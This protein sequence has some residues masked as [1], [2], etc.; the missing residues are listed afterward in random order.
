MVLSGAYY[1][2]PSSSFL[3]CHSVHITPRKM[4]QES[5][6]RWDLK[7]MEEGIARASQ[8]LL[9]QKL[10][11]NTLIPVSRLPIELLTEVFILY[12]KSQVAE[13]AQRL[14][15]DP[16]RRLSVYSWIS[17]SQ[18]C[19]Q[20]RQVALQTP[21][22][23]CSIVWTK[24][25][26][27]SWISE[28]L[29][30]SKSLLLRIR[31]RVVE[32]ADQRPVFPHLQNALA[33][34]LPEIHRAHSIDISLP[35]RFWSRLRKLE[36]TQLP[37]L[38]TL[39][40]SSPDVNPRMP[41]MFDDCD[42]PKLDRLG[43]SRIRMNCKHPILRGSMVALTLET[44][45][46]QDLINILAQMPRLAHLD[47][48]GSFV[49]LRMETPHNRVSFPSLATL[50]L[51]GNPIRLA[52]FWRS[53]TFPTTTCVTLDFK[54]DVS[55]L[56]LGAYD[57][58]FKLDEIFRS[59]PRRILCLSL[60]YDLRASQTHVDLHTEDPSLDLTGADDP[61][62]QFRITIQC[63]FPT[64]R[65]IIR[66]FVLQL[67]LRHVVSLFIQ[68]PDTSLSL[69][70]EYVLLLP[71]MP[72]LNLVRTTGFR[73]EH[74]NDIV[75]TRV[76]WHSGSIEYL[77]PQLRTLVIRNTSNP[78]DIDFGRWLRTRAT[79]GSMFRR[80]ILEKCRDI[81][82]KG[83]EAL[84]HNLAEVEVEWDNRDLSNEPSEKDIDLGSSSPQA[85]D[86]TDQADI[87]PVY[88]IEERQFVQTF[89][90]Y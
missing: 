12:V 58:S 81:N 89:D 27:T 47:L 6:P 14:R 2:I 4:P 45:V 40:L 8:A 11:F 29:A 51:V 33:V 22:L 13:N 21:I 35:A 54:R 24:R 86:N 31:I 79:S 88:N 84:K 38:K 48:S 32:G 39:T 61:T 65:D 75:R 20:W 49:I 36:A 80:L 50:R 77:V 42:M 68:I 71:K 30:R 90:L 56:R 76:A 55:N 34:L 46:T 70:N 26:S 52:G 74:I 60:W 62:P 69:S 5:S 18:V 53:I 23:W 64:F 44:E 41:T 78:C 59:D 3:R 10:H 72:S 87:R 82:E 37:H 67:P 83:V 57:V 19:H 43:Y 66:N 7:A 17:I 73:V 15:Q 9:A 25:I 85:N 63:S 1:I 28:L 16:P